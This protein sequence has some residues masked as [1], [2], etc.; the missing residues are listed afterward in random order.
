MVTATSDPE[1]VRRAPIQVTVG[2]AD[3][4]CQASGTPTTVAHSRNTPASRRR[5][6]SGPPT[7]TRGSST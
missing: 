4:L 7:T 3:V 1:R 6:S 5:S 2:P